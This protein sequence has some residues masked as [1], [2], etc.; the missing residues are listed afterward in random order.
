MLEVL[1]EIFLWMDTRGNKFSRITDDGILY[2]TSGMV[3]VQSLGPAAYE[4]FFRRFLL[5]RQDMSLRSW[6]DRR[7]VVVASTSVSESVVI[8]LSVVLVRRF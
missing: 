1:Q 2:Q 6:P 4:S 7:S 3:L 8:V 5:R